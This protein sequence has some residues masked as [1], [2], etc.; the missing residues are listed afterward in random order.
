MYPHF[1]H[2][3]IVTVLRLCCVLLSCKYSST[4]LSENVW[5]HALACAVTA[6]PPTRVSTSR[7]A[8]NKATGD[9]L[10]CF[11]LDSS[12]FFFVSLCHL[13]SFV[14]GERESR[15]CTPGVVV[16]VCFLWNLRFD[17]LLR[18]LIYAYSC[19][20]KH[21]MIYVN[22]SLKNI[23]YIIY[24]FSNIKRCFSFA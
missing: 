20:V 3:L 17:I 15:G 7:R 12:L 16:K 14:I 6:M 19:I 1:V 11:M 4:S 13:G 2:V 21:R 18:K 22:R 5:L 23:L 8:S 9:L 10:I 24:L